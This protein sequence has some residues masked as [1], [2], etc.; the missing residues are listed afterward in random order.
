MKK[1][2]GPVDVGI[3]V[4]HVK[5]SPQGNGKGTLRM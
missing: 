3:F 4:A 2:I 5:D 1:Y